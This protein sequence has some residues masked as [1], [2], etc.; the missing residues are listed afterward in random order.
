MKNKHLIS[1]LFLV[2]ALSTAG[3][4]AVPDWMGGRKDHTPILSGDRVAVLPQHI[5]IKADETLANVEVT[6]PAAHSNN[7]WSQHAGVFA[8][9]T[10]NLALAGS[11]E[12]AGSASIGEGESFEHTLIPSPVVADGMVFAMDGEGYI[13]AHDAKDISV[14][15]WQSSGVS[16]EDNPQVIGGGLAYHDGRL[17]VVSGRGLVVALDVSTGRQLWRK[18]TNIPFRSAPKVAENTLYAVSIDSQVYAF[19]MAT[20]DITWSQRGMRETTGILHSVSPAVSAGMVIVPFPSGEIYALSKEDGR[21]L[22]SK[23]LATPS[24]R[25]ASLFAGI[26]GDPVVDGD[27][28]F[29]VSTNGLFSVFSLFNGQP[30]WD[31]PASS[32]NTPWITGD[33]AYLLTTDNILISFVKYTGQVR[34]ATA[35]PSFEDEEDKKGSILWHGPVMAEGNLMLSGSHGAL[36]QVSAKS[37][38]IIGQHEIEEG[39]YTSPVIA[40]GMVYM[41]DRDATLTVLK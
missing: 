1:Y 26:G 8:P 13:S 5:S 9:T 16:E 35:L 41:V 25:A 32:L 29:A 21:E 30:L 10:S 4:N 33:Y 2:A 34:W 14:I 40:N 7:A 36:I 23:S 27:V 39:I 19:S 24:R 38:K 15:R 12:E 6:L 17:F 11:L 3:C 20:G 28:V 31:Y 18:A 22:W 37:G